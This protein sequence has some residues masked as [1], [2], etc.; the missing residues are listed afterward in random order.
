MASAKYGAPT[1]FESE[2]DEYKVNDNDTIF[3][4]QNK[5]SVQELK[6]IAKK[7]GFGDVDDIIIEKVSDGEKIYVV[8]KDKVDTI[9]NDDQ[10]C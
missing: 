3:V 2:S 9:L 7:K 5:Y 10:N 4:G 1:L 6:D 8:N